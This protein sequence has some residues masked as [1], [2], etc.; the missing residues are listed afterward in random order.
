VGSHDQFGRA[1]DLAL[2]QGGSKCIVQRRLPTF[3]GLFG[4]QEL[5]TK[6]MI[7]NYFFR[8]SV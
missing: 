6:T 8:N 2:R 5:K 4:E 1:V 3:Q 7:V